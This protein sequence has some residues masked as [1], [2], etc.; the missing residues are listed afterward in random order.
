VRLHNQGVVS[1]TSPFRA[2]SNHFAALG[3]PSNAPGF[4]NHPSFVEVEQAFPDFLNNYARF[5]QKRSYNEEYLEKARREVP[6]AAMALHSELL[7]D[8]RMGAC[9]D[10]AGVLSKCLEREGIWN[11]VVKGSLTIKFPA[12]ADVDDRYFWSVDEGNFTAGHAWVYAP[13]FSIV[14]VAVGQQ[15]YD[16][17]ERPWLPD[18]V[19]VEESARDAA[20]VQDII[21]PFV[22][23]QLSNACIPIG[24]MLAT[25][26]P[27]MPKFLETFPA[28]SVPHLKGA[29]LK[30]VPVAVSA[31]DG[32]LEDLIGIS[33]NGPSGIGIY[34][35]RI[36]PALQ[37]LRSS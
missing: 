3:I 34:Q 30:Y 4:Y 5:V 14:D 25:V 31:P 13:P 9:V 23:A 12:E 27:I 1:F 36:Q 10:A 28:A 7:A 33:T 15:D 19:I 2:I 22:F 29:I 24:K 16:P 18:T 26:N 32:E 20:K 6:V 21:S 37:A 8:G 17:E 35:N 11:F